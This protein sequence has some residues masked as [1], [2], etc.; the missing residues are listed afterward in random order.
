M[1]SPVNAATHYVN[2]DSNGS[3]SNP[4]RPFD[5]PGYTAND[6]YQTFTAAFNA[7]AAGDTIEFSG[8][9]NG[10]SYAGHTAS[11]DTQLTIQGSSIAGFNGAVTITNNNPSY[12][13]GANAD[14][15]VIQNLTISGS[16]SYVPLAIYKNNTVVKDVYIVNAGGNNY[17]IS[18]R[19]GSAHTTNF[20]N[21]VLYGNPNAKGI[22]FN[23]A[24]AGTANF[25]NCVVNGIADIAVSVH[26]GDVANFTNCSFTANGTLTGNIF[27]YNDGGTINTTNCLVQGRWDTPQTVTSGTG[28]KTWI[29]TSDILNAFP[30]Y[31][32]TRTNLGYLAFSTDDRE[33]LNYCVTNA[34][35]AMTRY[36]IPISCYISD[37]HR[38]N[39]ADK[40]KLQDLYRNG[41]EVGVHTRHHNDLS[42][43]DAI[44]IT[45]TG[46]HDDITFV[47][48]DS[49]T[50][51]SV[52]GSGD[53]HGPIN[54]TNTSYDTLGK[55]CT[56]IQSNWPN[57]ACSEV[58][59][60]SLYTPSVTLKDAST[61]L[62]ISV[63]TG[64]P[65][66]DS[67]GATNR[68][69]REEITNSIADLEAALHEDPACSAYTVKTLAFPFNKASSAVLNWIQEHTNL[70]GARSSDTV[71]TALQKTW[72][73]SIDVFNIYG[74]PT[75]STFIGD[76]SKGN[77]EQG[78]RVLASIASNGYFY[79]L[80]SHSTTEMT[81]QQWAWMI[82][83][84]AKYNGKYIEV[85]SFENIINTI[86]TSGHWVDSGG[87]IFT[88]DFSG[89][90]NFR[91]T[92]SSPMINAGITVPSRTA[93]IL[94][95]ELVGNPDIGPY[96]FQA[97]AATT[98]LSQY[99]SDG[100]SLI[101]SGGWTNETSV[102]L[103]FDM[104]STNSPD[105]LTP[106]V[107]VQPNASSFTD[108]MTHSGTEV[109]YS[110][111]PVPGSVTVS[112]LTDGVYHWQASAHNIVGTGPWTTKGGDPDFGVDTTAPTGGSIAYT[113]GYNSSTSVA[114][115]A[116]DGTDAHSGIDISTRTVQRRT[117]TLA[118]GA[119]S[120]YGEYST[121]AESGTYPNFTDTTIASGYCYQYQYLVSDNAGNQ[122]T[123][124]SSNTVKVDTTAPTAGSIAYTDGYNSSG[125][126]ALTA[127]DGT[128][129]HSGINIS[130]RIV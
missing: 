121:I 61:S 21:V 26:S 93:D 43:S 39:E 57:Y 31:K 51:L 103:K 99:K 81:H 69:Y 55:L 35:Y 50:S 44:S 6:S 34:N 16:G 113:D 22:E 95:N 90:D 36:N 58:T 105:S 14:N 40:T 25:Y 106:Y 47:V 38:L 9:T 60:I 13:L 119:C 18:L 96:E 83:E 2:A 45:Y 129:A 114:L 28:A 70:I 20:V 126:V 65:F 79:G 123:Y 78:A 7:A 32:S 8:G 112:G 4:T 115:T 84:V 42:L 53:T 104:S 116:N 11:I 19:T 62:P 68:Y 67:T 59:N 128:D 110:N 71:G 12:T 3:A 120:E 5:D 130:S 98:S 72:L 37:T 127:N 54:L 108:S 10:K 63:P 92:A 17:S 86:R 75:V 77:I 122:A 118:N 85:S 56:T 24:N 27:H 23:T 124:T 29:S 46:T 87:G 97:P 49:G 33:N 48:S 109:E 125:S 102:V 52:T 101:S 73:G 107:E 117:A 91:L 94:G 15:I 1:Y 74:R 82:D 89:N 30:H 88:R 111:S 100:A 76:G 64:I 80:L 41:H 66:D